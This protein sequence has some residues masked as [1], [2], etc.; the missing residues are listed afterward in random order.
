[1]ESFE[2]RFA[3]LTPEQQK[4]VED[5]A[6]FLL[7]KN[8]LRQTPV[9][10]QPPPVMLNTPP[11]MVPDSGVTAPRVVGIAPVILNPVESSVSLPVNDIRQHP[12]SRNYGRRRRL[13]LPR[14]YGLWEVRAAILS[15]N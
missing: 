9:V 10:S 6:D 5:F 11:V 14:L 1:M 15:C 8:T 7:L 4:E 13:D 12:Y 3:R 2:S